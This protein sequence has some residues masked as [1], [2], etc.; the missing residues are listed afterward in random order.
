MFW[1]GASYFE[2]L[3]RTDRRNQFIKNAVSVLKKWKKKNHFDAIAFRGMSGAIIAPVIAYEMNLPVIVI[4]KEYD[5]THD[6]RRV[7]GF[8]EPRHHTVKYIII[9]DFIETGNTV[10][11]IVKGVSE[12]VKDSELVG[13]FL[14]YRSEESSLKDYQLAPD[15]YS[16]IKA[17]PL[18]LV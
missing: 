2:D 11:E 5:D 17:M 4:R 8:V 14:Y 13:I 7:F 6:F 3:M 10:N 1:N 16:H 12:A 9:D 15:E 18:K